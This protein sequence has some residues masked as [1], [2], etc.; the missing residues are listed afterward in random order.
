MIRIK[1]HKDI[2][3][4]RKDFLADVKRIVYGEPLQKTRYGNEWHPLTLA[5]ISSTPRQRRAELRIKKF[6][7]RS[8]RV[9]V[10]I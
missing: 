10:L 6:N 4:L 3:R 9:E 1:I 7:R 8:E 2:R 5:L